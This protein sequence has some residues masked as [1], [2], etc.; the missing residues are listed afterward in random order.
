MSG[1][2]SREELNKTKKLW[3][4][5]L[6]KTISSSVEFNK[7]RESLGVHEHKDGY[8]RCKG[9]LSRGKL[10]FDAKLPILL[11]NSHHFTEL[12]IQ[13]THK[14]VHHNGVRETLLEIRLKYWIHKD[15]QTVKIILNKR[16]LCRKLE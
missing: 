14:K 3:I 9:Q 7:M 15:R 13:S 12:I 16:L 10:S 11:L 8:L 2:I 6:P 4:C 1:E 5:N